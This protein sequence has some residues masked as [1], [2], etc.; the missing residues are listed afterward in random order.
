[1]PTL[2]GHHLICLHFFDGEGYDDAFIRNLE[3]ILRRTE[4][5]DVEI[6][7]GADDV[8][9][10][11]LH[12]KE[13]RCMQ[14][15]GA[16]ESIRGMDEKAFELLGLSISDRVSWNV[17]Q[18]EIPGIFPEWYSLYCNECDWR[19]VCEKS[20]LFKEIASS[21]PPSGR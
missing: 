11:C 14:S 15:E 17:L 18:N 9:S 12:L 3:D 13:G 8:C 4:E 6:S 2:R 16:D 1:M 21:G 7:F 10:A 5:E 20:V 19:R